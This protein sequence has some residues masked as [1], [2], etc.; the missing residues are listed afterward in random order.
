GTVLQKGLAL[1]PSNPRLQYLQGMSL[2]NTPEAFGGGKAK[3]KPVFEKAV[4][5]FKSETIKPLHPRWGQKQAEDM[6]AQCQ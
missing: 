4:A 3:A 1:N 6:L 2:F 5:S